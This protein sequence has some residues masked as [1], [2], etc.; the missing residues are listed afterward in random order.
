MH[1]YIYECIVD[2]TCLMYVC[3]QSYMYIHTLIHLC[4]HISQNV[5]RILN[6]KQVQLI[7]KTASNYFIPLASLFSMITPIY[8]IAVFKN[9]QI[10]HSLLI[11]TYHLTFANG[12]D[13]VS[14]S[15]HLLQ[16]KL[17]FLY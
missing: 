7:T 11:K 6:E 4:P 16:S 12:L 2:T 5:C 8:C 15:D 10:K 17:S 1:M 9:I 3:M 13:Y 14:L